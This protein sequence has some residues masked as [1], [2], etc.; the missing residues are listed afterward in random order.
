MTAQSQHNI[1]AGQR[2]TMNQSFMIGF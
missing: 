1:I 2:L